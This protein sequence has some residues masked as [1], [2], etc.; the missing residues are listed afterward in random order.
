MIVERIQPHREPIVEAESPPLHELASG[1]QLRLV[2]VE[3]RGDIDEISIVGDPDFRQIRRLSVFDRI[4]LMEIGDRFAI[5]PTLVR[6]SVT[7][8]PD[9]PSC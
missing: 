8:P 7:P 6:N 4:D 1:N 2:I 5:A 9:G 3:L